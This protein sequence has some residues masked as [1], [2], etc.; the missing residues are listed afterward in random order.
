MVWHGRLSTVRE[1]VGGAKDAVKEAK[2]TAKTAVA[3]KARPELTAAGRVVRLLGGN[4]SFE[5]QARRTP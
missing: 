2:N 3:G 1:K 5:R 4:S